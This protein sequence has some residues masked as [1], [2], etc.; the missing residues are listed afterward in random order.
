MKRF[1]IAEARDNFTSLVH[2]AEGGVTVELTRRG[3]AVAVVMALTEYERLTGKRRRFSEAYQD[4]RR[5]NPDFVDNA[6]EP[7]EWLRDVRDPSP[8]KD[9]S[10]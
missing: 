8:G 2:V 1:S 7:E 5:R 9:F 4:F 3:K 6:V 10:W